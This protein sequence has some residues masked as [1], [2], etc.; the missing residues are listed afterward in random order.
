MNTP[1]G[2]KGTLQVVSPSE[3]AHRGSVTGLIDLLLA[4]HTWLFCPVSPAD[5]LPV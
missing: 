1:L 3:L 5:K 4:K 2:L